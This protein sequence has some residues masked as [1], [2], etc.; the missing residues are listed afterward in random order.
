MDEHKTFTIIVERKRWWAQDATTLADSLTPIKSGR[1][2]P[3]CPWFSR[4]VAL[5]T[6]TLK[7]ELN[8]IKLATD[9]SA[10]L[11]FSYKLN[12]F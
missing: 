7:P 4:N 8:L 5:V 9:F 10:P 2:F 3:G 6:Q 12:Y 11:I 1:K